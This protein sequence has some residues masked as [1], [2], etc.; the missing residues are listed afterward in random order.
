[1]TDKNEVRRKLLKSLAAGSGAVVAGKNL[2]ESWSKPVID[3]VM[4]PVHAETTDDNESGGPEVTT[5]AIPPCSIPADCYYSIAWGSY[6]NWAGGG[7]QRLVHPNSLE[8]CGGDEL[9]QSWLVVVA[10]SIDE[11]NALMTDCPGN[12][13]SPMNVPLDLEGDCAFYYCDYDI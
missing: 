12:N 7:G 6:F 1:M 4:L 10:S 11:A 2:P 8:V 9:P 13:A 5:T 3:S